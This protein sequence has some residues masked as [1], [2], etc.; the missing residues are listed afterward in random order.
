MHREEQNRTRIETANLAEKFRRKSLEE[1]RRGR[2]GRSLKTFVPALREAYIHWMS[3]LDHREIPVLL[4]GEK[5]TGKRTHVDE[6]YY[7]QNLHAGFSGESPGRLRVFRGDF[8]EKGFS[9]LLYAPKT[10]HEDVIYIEHIDLLNSDCQEEMLEYL[11]VRKEMGQRGCPVPR[12]FMGTEKALSLNVMRGSF[13]KELFQVLTGFAIFLPSIKDRAQDIPH[14]LIE[15]IEDLS[16]KKQLPPVWLVDVLSGQALYENMTELKLILKN[17]LARKPEVSTWERG[18]LDPDSG[19]IATHHFERLKPQN[20][21][22]QIKDRNR[23]ES[24]LSAYKG[25]SFKAAHALGMSKTEV[26]KKM[27]VYGIR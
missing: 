24:V 18:D 7:L 1:A 3:L 27:M 4:Y 26:L 14:L 12:L 15:M 10:R 8:L 22:Q 25:D 21:N 5:G 2:L 23:L 17:L 11:K 9:Q 16:G 13:S 6:Y 19:G 20:V